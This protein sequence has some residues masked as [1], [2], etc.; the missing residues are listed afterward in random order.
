MPTAAPETPKAIISP[1]TFE[2]IY[3]THYNSFY[4]Y[5]LSVF[6]AH[7]S[8][9]VSVSGRAEEAVQE[10]FAFAWE[11]QSRMAQAPSLHGWLF[12]VLQ[13]K[14]RELL[15]EDRVWTKRMLQI[16]EQYTARDSYDFRLKTELEDILEPAD[17]LL[18]KHLYLDGYTYNE[19]CASTGLKK[20]ALAM[21]VRR[22]KDGF[23][24]EYEA[25]ENFSQ[26]TC[27]QS[28]LGGQFIVEEV[29][30]DGT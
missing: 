6:K 27:E 22:I 23:I 5:A 15:R 11:N 1:E 14:V 10:M 17:Y 29:L 13:F 3:K 16:S 4:R 25:G 7:G 12:S 8:Q 21:R 18:L 2:Q 30:G 9:Y 19:V 24:R 20:S 28:P 26:N